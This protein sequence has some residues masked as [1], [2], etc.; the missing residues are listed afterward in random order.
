MIRR[1]CPFAI[2]GAIATMGAADAV[3][4]RNANT[5]AVYPHLDVSE[6]PSTN[7]SIKPII[8]NINPTPKASMMGLKYLLFASCLATKSSFIAD[9]LVHSGLSA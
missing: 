9:A 5:A 6:T 7:R 8:P 2:L 1:Q 4:N 3:V